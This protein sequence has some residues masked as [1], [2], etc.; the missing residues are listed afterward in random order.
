MDLNFLV[1]MYSSTDDP[2]LLKFRDA[3]PKIFCRCLISGSYFH[4]ATAGE[5]FIKRNL[6]WL[7]KDPDKLALVLDALAEA[8]NEPER[9]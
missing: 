2:A 7:Y 1:R 8:C 6:R 4:F 3:L 5:A 9:I